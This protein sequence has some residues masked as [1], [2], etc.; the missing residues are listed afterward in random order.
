MTLSPSIS[1]SQYLSQPL[2]RKEELLRKHL[3]SYRNML[4][5]YSGGVD[6]SLLLYVAYQ[7]LGERTLG[8]IADSPS[9]AREELTSARSFAEKHHLPLREIQTQ[10]LENPDY[11][12]NPINRCFYCKHELF[13]QM[14]Q[15][16]SDESWE[17]LAY[18]ENNDDLADE[19]PGRKAAG[20][21]DVISPLAHAGLSKQD[22]RDLAQHYGLEVSDKVASPCLASRIMQGIEV[23]PE[24]L[25]Q[26]EQAEQI[27][28]QKG[29]EILRV[30]HRKESAH[31]QVSPEETPKLLEPA[32]K[33]ELEK[34]LLELG[35]AEVTFDTEGYQG[36]SLR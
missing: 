14:N 29:F 36:A 6:S 19:R 1:S 31:V 34:Q 22:I 33:A 10:E 21:F 16:A 13:N 20:K 28:R 25:H 27:V 2:Q 4:V 30:R 3:R 12:A 17:A 35:F 15:I 32:T 8:I 26:V 18:G 23:T 9:L 11:A 24:R 7:E 5:A